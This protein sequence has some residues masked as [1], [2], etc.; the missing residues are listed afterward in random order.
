MLAVEYMKEI[1]WWLFH[2]CT[3]S[4][5]KARGRIE[6]GHSFIHIT[7]IDAYGDLD[8]GLER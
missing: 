8:V 4:V 6:R 2:S 7:S 3:I 1:M 5:S